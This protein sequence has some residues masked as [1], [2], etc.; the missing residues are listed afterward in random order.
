MAQK[1]LILVVLAS[2]CCAVF[3]EELCHSFGGGHVYPGEGMRASEHAVHWSKAQ[4]KSV[5]LGFVYDECD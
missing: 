1:M 4:S 2:I 5:C 3:G